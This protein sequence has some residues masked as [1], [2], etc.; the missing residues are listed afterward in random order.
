MVPNAR[1]NELLN[2]IEPSATTT[3]N[4]STAHNGLRSHL[5]Q[6]KTFKAKWSNDFLAGSYSRDT[7]L[8]PR[9]TED[10]LERP[11]VDI[12]VETTYV[13]SDKP[14]NVLNELSE[15]LEEEYTVE[16]V[17]MRSVRVA[18]SYAEMD[19]VP[20]IKAFDAFV[21]A[22]RESDSWK[23][24]NPPKHDEWSTAQNVDLGGRFKPLVKLLKSWRRHNPSGRRPKGFVLELL[25]AKHAPRTETHYGEA[26]AQTLESIHAAYSSLAKA[27]QKPQLWDPAI[28]G[29]D[30]LSKVSFAQWRDFIE[31]VRVHAGYAR[32][33]QKT[34]DMDRAT[35]LWQRLFG[36]RFRGTASPLKSAGAGTL[37]S[38]VVPAGGY[39]FPKQDASP[40]KPR[41]F[42]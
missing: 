22:D 33:A 15:V 39:T 26:F 16:R 1:F 27:G 17:N 12:I 42:A 36:D 23:P 3:A 38:A 20:V 29:N 8:R 37:A 18:T 19:V 30:V 32:D 40:K 13:P 2:D 6:H 31:K 10:G 34:D 7:A 28:R 41:G 5:R 21:I 9:T 35:E 14:E 24:T 25:V 4:A 11:D